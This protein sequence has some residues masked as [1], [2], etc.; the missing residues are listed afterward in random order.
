VE[1]VCHRVVFVKS[2]HV[3]AVETMRAGA[4]HAR[5]LRVRLSTE[6][7][8]PSAARLAELA[9]AGG[10]AF[11]GWSAPDARFTV[12]DD[13]GATQLLQAL[14]RDGVAVIEVVPEEGRL[15]RLFTEGSPV[16]GAAPGVVATPEPSVPA[17]DPPPAAERGDHSRFMPPTSGGGA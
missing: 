13:R 4:T 7:A 8:E 17:P 12:A 10:A 11:R 15:E 2:G 16:A 5:V 3:E 6:Q 9:G 14:L 1:R